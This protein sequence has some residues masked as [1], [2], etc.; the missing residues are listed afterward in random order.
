[1][2]R[3]IVPFNETT[4][5]AVPSGPGIYI[6]YCRA[7]RRA[8]YVGRSRRDIR[9][10]LRAHVVGQGSK[11]LREA[12]QRGEPLEFEWMHMLSPEQAESQLITALG[13]AAYYNLRR[14]TDPADWD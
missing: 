2:F 3:R 9:A 5:Q 1:M 7:T 10:R 13:T 8:A 11:R 4:V 14:E 6:V 12:M